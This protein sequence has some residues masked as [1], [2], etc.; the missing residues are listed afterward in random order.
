VVA[1]GLLGVDAAGWEEGA[2]GVSVGCGVIGANPGIAV[3]GA[4][5][6]AGAD[7]TG[8][9][10][11]MGLTG[12]STLVGFVID[13]TQLLDVVCQTPDHTG[14]PYGFGHVLVI[15][16]VMLPV[17]PAGHDRVCVCVLI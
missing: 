3:A 5:G 11:L 10:G 6:I 1:A 4:V 2:S 15:D 7:M 8:E 17:N 16:W 12:D 13:F 9:T 14:L